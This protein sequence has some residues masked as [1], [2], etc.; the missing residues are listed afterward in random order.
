MA[1]KSFKIISDGNVIEQELLEKAFDEFDAVSRKK[2]DT[3]F[4]CKVKPNN[5]FV[6]NEWKECISEYI[7]LY[8]V[9]AYAAKYA[10]AIV[11]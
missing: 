8:I 1:S 7:S 3:L 9:P 5:L 11:I 6:L 2:S 10:F 4:H